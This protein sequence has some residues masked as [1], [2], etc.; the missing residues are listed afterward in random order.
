[1]EKWKKYWMITGLLSIR[2][3]EYEGYVFRKY[4][5]TQLLIFL[6]RVR[7]VEGGMG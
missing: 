3:E 4:V 2:K 1:M 5:N 6:L 7:R